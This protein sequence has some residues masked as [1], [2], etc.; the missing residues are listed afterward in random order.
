[1]DSGTFGS[2]TQGL[3]RAVN[4]LGR[5]GELGGRHR[6]F[7][8]FEVPDGGRRAGKDSVKRMYRGESHSA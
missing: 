3:M 2:P 6:A 7:G 4:S 1:M 5:T 8:T